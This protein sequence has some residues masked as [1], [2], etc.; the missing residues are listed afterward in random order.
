MVAGMAAA[1]GGMTPLMGG[2]IESCG[3]GAGRHAGWGCEGDLRFGHAEPLRTQGG[4]GPIRRVPSIMRGHSTRCEKK[5]LGGEEEI[6]L[7]RRIGLA[8]V[9]GGCR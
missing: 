2:L 3:C 8:T 7:L 1:E 9:V 6:P 5:I 4:A